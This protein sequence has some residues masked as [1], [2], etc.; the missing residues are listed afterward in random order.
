MKE[1]HLINKILIVV[2]AMTGFAMQSL[3]AA[4]N[5][6]IVVY[7]AS[8]RVGE[9]IVEV[10]LER[11]HKV[12]GISR[13]PEKLQFKHK[14]FTAAQGDLMDVNSIAGFARGADAL[15]ISVSAKASDNRPEN[16]LIVEATRNVQEALSKLESKPYIVQ[17]GSANLMYGST[18][19]EVSKNMNKVHFPYEEGTPMYAVLFGHQLSLQSYQASTLDWTILAPPLRI[20]GIYADK[21][22]TTARGNYRTST[23]APLVA[24]DGSKSIYVRDLAGAT[25]NEIEN[26]NFVRQ[27][28]TVA[29]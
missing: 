4:D 6:S 27:V 14:N 5:L 12:T 11:G 19:A 24:A 25:V 22:K 17:I 18:F 15:V 9:V 21:D 13:H 2:L 29:Y 23:S 10:A 7:G 20:L 16:S 26:R 8:G 28:F 3:Q 1:A